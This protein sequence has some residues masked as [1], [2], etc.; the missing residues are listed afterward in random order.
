MSSTPIH[1]KKAAELVADHLRSEI[2]AGNL[3]AGS[4]LPVERELIEA[5]GVSRPTLR[6]ALRILETEGLLK[7]TR[8]V[9]G[10]AKVIG[11]SLT[12]ATHALGMLLQAKGTP[13]VDV[14][15][16]RSIIEPPAARMVAERHAPEDLLVLREALGVERAALDT[17]D[18]PFAA[19]RFHET[20]VGLC[21]NDTID[22]FSQ[23]L[24]DIHRGAA[25]MFSKSRSASTSWGRIIEQHEQLIAYIES[26]D[27]AAAEQLWREYWA[28]FLRDR[29]TGVV[30]VL[31]LRD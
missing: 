6:E 4:T 24:H 16:A 3:A 5:Y 31:N 30:D 2:V 27:G 23:I 28:P 22:A 17:T 19:M 25:V 18:F 21:G 7:V 13:L 29:G 12:L 9:K 11:P 1:L 15:I 26:G 20:L 8:G 10:G 14:Q